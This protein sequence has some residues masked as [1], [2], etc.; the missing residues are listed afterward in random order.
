MVECTAWRLC[1]SYTA[2]H[3]WKLLQLF[4]LSGLPYIHFFL[5]WDKP[6]S[7]EFILES[8]NNI[9]F[10]HGNQKTCLLA[11]GR[12]CSNYRQFLASLKVYSWSFLPRHASLG[13]ALCSK[14]MF[15]SLCRSGSVDNSFF[16]PSW[17]S[18]VSIHTFFYKNLCFLLAGHLVNCLL[19]EAWLPFPL[20][21][22]SHR[23][24]IISLSVTI[25][26]MDEAYSIRLGFTHDYIS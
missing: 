13:H 20:R 23:C 6:T 11:F 2:L 7:W 16:C 10:L 18:L 12:N 17:S 3:L 25:I 22:A 15:L 24:M 5:S 14:C 26:S 21:V 1:M 8:E 19:P 9:V 4:L